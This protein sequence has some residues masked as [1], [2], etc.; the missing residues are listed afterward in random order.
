MT[1]KTDMDQKNKE[2]GPDRIVVIDRRPKYDTESA[3]AEVETRYPTYVEEIEARAEQA[4]Q[5]AREISAAYRRIDQERDAF[6]DRLTRDLERRV[7]IARADLM[8]KILGVV[9]DLDRAIA[10]ARDMTEP[11]PL[12]DGVSLI[13]DRLLKA[14]TSEGVETIDTSGKQFDPAV[15]E[16]IATETI[17]EPERDNVVLEELQR[18]Y[19]LRGTLLRPARV[20]VARLK[21]SQDETLEKAPPP[22]PIEKPS[23]QS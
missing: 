2:A 21:A 6:R 4:E 22:P 7:D 5:R 14:L 3:A 12:L 8:R 10:A 1:K 13:R 19:M 17:T 23:A 16:A 15:A 18:G 11:S 9:D 20:R